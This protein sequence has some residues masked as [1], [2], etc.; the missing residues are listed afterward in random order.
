MIPA[1]ALFFVLRNIR[2]AHDEGRPVVGPLHAARV[3]AITALLAQYLYFLVAIMGFP[4]F[5]SLRFIGN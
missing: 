3:V 5:A 1:V 2:A 4:T